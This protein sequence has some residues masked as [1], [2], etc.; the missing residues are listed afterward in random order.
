MSIET[1][2]SEV[3]TQTVDA[4]SVQ[5]TAIPGS[6]QPIG[7]LYRSVSDGGGLGRS[8]SAI[9]DLRQETSKRLAV[10]LERVTS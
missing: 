6:L 10:Q 7:R 1:K 4:I 8:K 3:N 5:N 9:L 2:I